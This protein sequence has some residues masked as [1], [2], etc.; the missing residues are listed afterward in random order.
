VYGPPAYQQQQQPFAGYGGG[1]N[2]Y[3]GGRTVDVD[4]GMVVAEDISKE[5]DIKP[6]HLRWSTPTIWSKSVWHAATQLLCK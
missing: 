3:Q 5:E 1:Y 2:N 4:V 6:P